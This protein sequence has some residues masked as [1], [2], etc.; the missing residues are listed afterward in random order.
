MKWE[1]LGNPIFVSL[2]GSVILILM[3]IFLR[4]LLMRAVLGLNMQHPETL[5]RSHPE[6]FDSYGPGGSD[7]DLGASTLDP[8]AIFSR[9]GCGVCHRDKGTHSVC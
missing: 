2:I 3:V 4:M 6:F 9:L 7:P 1:W 8:S 5:D